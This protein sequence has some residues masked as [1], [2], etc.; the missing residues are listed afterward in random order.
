MCKENADGDRVDIEFTGMPSIWL[1]NLMAIRIENTHFKF[2]KRDGHC[3]GMLWGSPST[4]YSMSNISAVVLC[5]SC[6]S[7]TALSIQLVAF[8]CLCY[9]A[10]HSIPSCYVL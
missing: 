1:Q 4:R 10:L 2:G 6:S 7:F 5:V 9:F 3:T 8:C